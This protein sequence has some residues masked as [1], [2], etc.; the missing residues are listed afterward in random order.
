MPVAECLIGRLCDT[1]MMVAAAAANFSLLTAMAC[2]WMLRLQTAK[3]AKLGG[4]QTAI[5]AK[6]TVCSLCARKRKC[7][8]C[9]AAMLIEVMKTKYLDVVRPR[10][11]RLV[12]RVAGLVALVCSGLA[13]AGE[14]LI[15]RG[16]CIS[17]HRV[18]E[19]LIGPSFK[20]VAAKY[21]GSKDAAEHLFEVVRNGG[22]GVWGD[23]P[24][25]AAPPE[26]ISDADLR[27]AIEFILGLP[28][29]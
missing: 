15:E 5:Y 4:K 18:D 13:C 22:E 10:R 3:H 23:L 1:P 21:R 12:V 19:K 20:D 11:S 9:V 17:C 29:S 28:R 24:M 7:S 6:E 25:P 16:G 27:S 14:E 2:A 26:K 8:E